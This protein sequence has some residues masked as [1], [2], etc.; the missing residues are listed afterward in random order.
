MGI[1]KQERNSVQGFR[2]AIRRRALSSVV[3]GFWERKFAFLLSLF[4]SLQNREEEGEEEEVSQKTEQGRWEG[5]LSSGGMD[6]AVPHM[7]CISIY[8]SLK[9]HS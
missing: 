1:Q 8:F 4:L 7:A 3:S 9:H 2:D 5:Y 6:T